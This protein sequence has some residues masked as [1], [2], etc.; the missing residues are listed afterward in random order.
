M[1]QIFIVQPACPFSSLWLCPEDTIFWLGRG[2]IVLNVERANP[3]LLC[4]LIVSENCQYHRRQSCRGA[5]W[6]WIMRLRRLAVSWGGRPASRNGAAHGHTTAKRRAATLCL[7]MWAGSQS[8]WGKWNKKLRRSCP[9]LPWSFTR[10]V[11]ALL[12]L[13][14]CHQPFCMALL[15]RCKLSHDFFCGLSQRETAQ[16][17]GKAPETDFFKRVPWED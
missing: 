16:L 11:D 7:Q 12:L 13:S 10:S 17:K 5:P 1:F 3:L 9:Q 15:L 8:P 4:G 6:V 14:W 2:R